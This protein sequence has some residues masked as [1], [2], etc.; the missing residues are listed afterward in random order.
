MVSTGRVLVAI[1][2]FCYECQNYSALNEHLVLL[3]KR[4]SQL[5]QVRFV[6][7]SFSDLL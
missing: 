1:V 2:N 5:K 6:I 3:T 4:R 7:A